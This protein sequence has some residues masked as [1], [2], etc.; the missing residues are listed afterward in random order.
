[1][2]HF[3]IALITLTL[4]ALSLIWLPYLRRKQQR[5][6][7]AEIRKQ[8]N[9]SLYHERQQE[10]VNDCTDGRISDQERQI[11]EQELQRMLLQNV[12]KQD[13]QLAHAN[14]SARWPL[15][16]SAVLVLTSS[17]IYYDLGRANDWQLA[18]QTQ[19]TAEHSAQTV[20]QMRAMRIEQMEQALANNPN[21]SQGWFDLGH[22]YMDA[23]LFA[24][25]VAAF[26]SAMA[27]VGEHADLL[28]PKATA[29]YYQAN[30][31][32]TPAVQALIQQ[33][34][35]DDEQDPSTRLLLGMDAFFNANYEE[36]IRHWEIILTSPHSPGN[37]E[38]VR[39]AIAQAKMFLANEENTV[40][41]DPS[42]GVTVTVDLSL[43]MKAYA[44]PN[45]MIY[46]I[47]RPLAEGNPTPVA[48]A[49]I[50][51]SELPTTLLL[52][53]S[54]AMSNDALISATEYVEL[55][56]AINVNNSP[57]P[58]PGDLFGELN[59]VALGSKVTL[60]I[61]TRIP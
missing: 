8:T 49:Q 12:E 10:L 60:I 54:F 6:T 48:L 35:A 1:M 32:M 23:N 53:D 31:T 55:M 61:N 7:D 11:L 34:L 43:E 44:K 17:Y 22:A 16:M 47:A 41:A 33:A 27:L 40:E 14:T 36:A 5:T 20:Q 3:W 13:E 28:G 26:D 15:L 57:E 52:D 9:L 39:S 42:Q 25:S 45:D 24:Q 46:L 56:A 2:T 50:K 59:Y 21:N 38:G 29:L 4:L 51:V 30:Q 37:N 19:N 18:A 58:S